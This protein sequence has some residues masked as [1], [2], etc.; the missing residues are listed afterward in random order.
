MLWDRG[1]NSSVDTLKKKF[2]PDFTYSGEMVKMIRPISQSVNPNIYN[3]T[4]WNGGPG[5]SWVS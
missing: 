1:W 3:P 4:G 2:L 5:L